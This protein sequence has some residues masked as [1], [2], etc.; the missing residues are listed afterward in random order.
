M[1]LIRDPG[2][3]DE[4]VWRRLWAGYIAFYEAEVPEA[5]T[6]VTWARILDPASPMFA[7][8]AE[9]DGDVVG[10]ANAVLHEATWTLAP[11]CYLED[12][13]VDPAVRGG[14]VGHALIQDL[15]EQGRARG[16]ARIYWHTR[17]DNAV[18]RRLYDR[19]VEVDPFVRYRLI[20]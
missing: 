8:L 11:S 12:L 5:V 16:W 9:R 14:G 7:R 6:A 13:F 1:T 18:A 20:L 3:A 17:G 19:F 15:V 4:P 2:P 10:F